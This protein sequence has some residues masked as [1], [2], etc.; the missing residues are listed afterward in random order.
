MR[1]VRRQARR[2]A[3]RRPATT[4]KIAPAR[5]R[6]LPL[7]RRHRAARSS[8]TSATPAPATSSTT[9]SSA[10]CRSAS[11]SARATSTP[12][13]SC[14]RA[15]STARKETVKLDEVTRRLAPRRSST[16]PTTRCSTRPRK[17]REENTPRRRHL[18]R[19]EADPQG[20]GRLRPLLL[21]ARPRATRRRSRSETKATVRV[22]PVRPAGRR[23]A[24]ASTRARRRRR[25]CC[26]RR[27]IDRHVARVLHPV[28]ATLQDERAVH[29]TGSSTGLLTRASESSRL[30]S[31][32]DVHLER[33]LLQLHRQVHRA[34]RD[35]RRHR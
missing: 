16:R 27:R 24:R 21:Q 15:A 6:E 5:H 11:K 4:H 29:T 9:G 28:L 33:Q 1:G 32:R 12:A 17:F 2:R 23:R 18:R 20:A 10:A 25:R 19:D 13:R 35:L 22:H 26:S 3:D 8:P 30:F 31:R 34:H 14:S 7:R